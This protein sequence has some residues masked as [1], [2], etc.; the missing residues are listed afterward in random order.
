M[1]PLYGYTSKR[2]SN[3]SY[4]QRHSEDSTR[5]VK[6]DTEDDIIQSLMRR[7]E[8]LE[9]RHTRTKGS[10]MAGVEC[11]NCHRMG[12]YARECHARGDNQNERNRGANGREEEP[13]NHSL[14]GNG[15]TLL[16]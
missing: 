9:G 5:D 15:P 14:N 1:E 7:I 13:M 10:K 12:H 3:D 6:C 16:A 4:S 2:H 11:F 8:R